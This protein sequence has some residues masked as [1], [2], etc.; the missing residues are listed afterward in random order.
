MWDCATELLKDWECMNSL[1]LE[2]PLSGEEGKD[3]YV[4]VCQYC[5]GNS[6]SF[7]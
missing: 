7:C 5:F 4:I 3:N 6:V 1:L 2:E